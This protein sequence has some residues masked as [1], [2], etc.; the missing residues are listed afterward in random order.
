VTGSLVGMSEVCWLRGG[1]Q[2]HRAGFEYVA[3]MVCAWHSTW[4]N[5]RRWSVF[6][7]YALVL[8][9]RMESGAS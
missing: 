5:G 7:G 4:V 9:S 8:V 1:Q 6:G 3:N 2:L